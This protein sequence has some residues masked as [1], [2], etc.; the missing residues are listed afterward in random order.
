MLVD[1]KKTLFGVASYS[2][3]QIISGPGK[4]ILAFHLNPVVTS[5]RLGINSLA[6]KMLFGSA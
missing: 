5:S 1:R 2:S 4:W 3:S 6:P